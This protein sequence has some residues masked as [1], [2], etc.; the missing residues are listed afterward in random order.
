MKREN[1]KLVMIND[2]A[3]VGETLLKYMPPTIER[4]HIKRTRGLWSK[5]FG[6]TYKIL[7]AK[8]DVYHSNYLLQ[9][10]Y[11]AVRL[12]KKPIVGYALGSDL[13][14]SLKHSLWG[15]VVRHNVKNC[16]KV[17]VSTPD[18]LRVAKQF[19]NDAEY[20]P[21]AV[22][23]EL[24]Y[25][26]PPIQHKGKK[27]VL[28][29]S[30]S[31]WN[32]KGTDIAIRALSKLKDEVETSII[33]H[34]TDFNKTLSLASSLDLGLTVLPTT[35]HENIREYYWNADIVVDQFKFGCA[36]MISLEAIACGRPAIAYVTSEYQEYQH[37]PVKDLASE[38]QIA[39]AIVEADDALWKK[40]YEYLMENHRPES[41][42]KKLLAIYDSATNH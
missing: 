19:R 40:E 1:M 28:I 18:I 6:V 34:G 16:N 35:P 3:N 8:G 15:R 10:C 38:E 41:V 23:T 33:R 20:L 31:N 26:K 36:G 29:A 32:V 25:P 4:Q 39:E 13:R 14:T 17:L 12:G 42:L 22:D 30:N 2:C 27:K 21:P 11:V 5:T 37:F 7:R 9:D 24:F